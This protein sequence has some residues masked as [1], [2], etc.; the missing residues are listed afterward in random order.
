[1][2]SILNFLLHLERSTTA[3]APPWTWT[4]T[5]P[6]RR[7]AAATSPTSLNRPLPRLPWVAGPAPQRAITG[8]RSSVSQGWEIM[9]EKNSISPHETNI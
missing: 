7:A 6:S 4:W 9:S 2:S 8:P 1:M 3:A 5:R